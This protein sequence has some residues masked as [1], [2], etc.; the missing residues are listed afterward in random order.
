MHH[1][2]GLAKG[3]GAHFSSQLAQS[4]GPGLGML[5]LWTLV[6]PK[7]HG[8]QALWPPDPQ[9]P[10]YYEGPVCGGFTLSETTEHPFESPFTSRSFCVAHDETWTRCTKSRCPKGKNGKSRFPL[11]RVAFEPRVLSVQ[12]L[13]LLLNFMGHKPHGNKE[14]EHLCYYKSVKTEAIFHGLRSTHSWPPA[15]L[16]SPSNWF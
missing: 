15:S 4:I 9:S 7:L 3:F 6:V 11:V 2:V 12:L 13:R 1:F 10:H 5:T 16:D 14:S 8:S